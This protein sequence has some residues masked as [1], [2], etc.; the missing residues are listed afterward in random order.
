MNNQ[1]IVTSKSLLNSAEKSYKNTQ[2]AVTFVYILPIVAILIMV[3]VSKVSEVSFQEMMQ[4]AKGTI[5]WLLWCVCTVLCFAVGIKVG[6]K[7]RKSYDRWCMLCA[8]EQLTLEASRLYGKT[9]NQTIALEYS[10]LKSVFYKTHNEVST[11]VLTTVNFVSYELII[12]DKFG[13]EYV[14]E[15]FE[16]A[17]ELCTIIQSKI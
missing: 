9:M 17:K 1:I 7:S 11:G 13:V 6:R 4:G 14:F 8:N 5:F 16:N 15:S 10:Q 3:L 12:T 2:G